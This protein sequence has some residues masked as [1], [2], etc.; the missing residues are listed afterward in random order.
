[1]FA[2]LRR[3]S[4]R[5]GRQQQLDGTL[6]RACISACLARAA[7]TLLNYFADVFGA[8]ARRARRRGAISHSDAAAAVVAAAAAAAT[9]PR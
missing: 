8:E 2:R 1:M 3:T 7:A 5:A 6:S 4:A 9:S